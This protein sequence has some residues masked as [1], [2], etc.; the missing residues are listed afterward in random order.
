MIMFKSKWAY[1]FLILFGF[2]GMYGAD[3]SVSISSGSKTVAVGDRFR[4]TVN[5]QGSYKKFNE[6]QFKDF[7]VENR[8]QSTSTSISIINGKMQRSKNISYSYILSPLKS[9]V[10]TI[11]P[12]SLVVEKKGEIKSN[13]ITVTVLDAPV[14][15]TPDPGRDPAGGLIEG[16]GESDQGR[17]QSKLRAPLTEWEKRTENFFIR[18][19]IEGEGDFYEGEPVTIKYYIFTRPGAISNIVNYEIPEFENSWKEEITQPRLSFNRIMIGQVPYDHS[20]LATFVL[21]PEKGSGQLRGTQMVVDLTTGGFFNT[22]RHT[23]SSPAINIP[24]KP[25]EEEEGFSGGVFGEFTISADRREVVLDRENPLDSVSFTISG[26]GNLHKADIDLPKVEGIQIFPPDIKTESSIK[27]GKLCGTKRFNYILKGLKPGEYPL[28]GH[29]AAF[30]NREKGWH[31]INI[32]VVNINVKEVPNVSS[33][34]SGE[35]RIKY[36][37]LRELPSGLRVYGISMITERIWFKIGVVVP[38]ILIVVS[39]FLWLIKGASRKISSSFS[40][41]LKLWEEKCRKSSDL[42]DLMNT[43]YDALSSLYS[44]E[45]RGERQ[46]NIEKKYGK[47]LREVCLFIKEMQHSIYSGESEVDMDEFREKAV[48]LLNPG[49]YRK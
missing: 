33:T 31:K 34:I 35:R 40:S 22:R 26:C 5:A 2:A 23:I 42:N 7:N 10:F 44:I 48:K 46:V 30:F 3:A 24:L 47:S 6:P 13:T 43:V 4:V 25:F 36:E 9:G 1:I 19:V 45:L 28:G 32:P 16:P 37:V 14:M 8:S 49:V 17:L 18:S 15:G 41:N 21:I 29:Y 38:F 20:L 39:M 11:G 12:A 27:G